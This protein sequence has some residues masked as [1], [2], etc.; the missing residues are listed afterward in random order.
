MTVTLL[1]I[2]HHGPGSAR[3]LRAALEELQPNVVLIEGPPDADEFIPLVAHAKTEPPI[4][5]LVYAADDPK[6]AAFYPFALF[7]PEW[8]AITYAL[9]EVE[10]DTSR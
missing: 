1:G 5:L 9:E 3:S 2:R 7:S 10:M 6:Q 8:Q 4:A